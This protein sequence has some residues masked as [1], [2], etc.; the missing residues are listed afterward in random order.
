VPET[1]LGIDTMMGLVRGASTRR[2]FLEIA[3]RFLST[4]YRGVVAYRAEA[5]WLVPVLAMGEVADWPRLRS[6]AIRIEADC[7]LAEHA[8]EGC[9]GRFEAELDG[10]NHDLSVW[11]AGIAEAQS[12]VLP[13]SAGGVIQYLFYAFDQRYTK[14]VSGKLMVQ[15]QKE[16][17]HA[18]GVMIVRENEMGARELPMSRP[19]RGRRRRMP[20]LRYSLQSE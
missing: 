19:T 8:R 17:E 2:R 16:L 3:L 13:V 15:L 5:G 4:P 11:S 20:S 1:V 6:C 12:A 7:S 10:L 9:A 18:L 14:P